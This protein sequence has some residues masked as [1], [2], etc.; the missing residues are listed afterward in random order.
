MP[1]T[2]PKQFANLE[3][4]TGKPSYLKLERDGWVV[5]YW[6]IG[7]ELQAPRAVPRRLSR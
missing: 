4:A 2:W 7:P 1:T 3:R 5:G 6:L